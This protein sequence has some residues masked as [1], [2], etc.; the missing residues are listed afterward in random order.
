M[1][2]LGLNGYEIWILMDNKIESGR[3]RH[4][5]IVGM[6]LTTFSETSHNGKPHSKSIM[7]T[8][9]NTHKLIHISFLETLFPLKKK[10]CFKRIFH[11]TEFYVAFTYSSIL[12]QS[13]CR[14]IK[15][16]VNKQVFSGCLWKQHFKDFF[17][18]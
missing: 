10:K 6:V 9:A 8:L 5:E 16:S 4:N 3:V 18:F 12:C 11:Y 15:D 14:S 13:P 2:L 17:F 1:K 7:G